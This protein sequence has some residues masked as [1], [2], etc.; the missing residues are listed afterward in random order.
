MFFAN[1]SCKKRVYI[2]DAE[3]GKQYFCPC[4]NRELIMK[5]GM[6]VASHFAH[7]IGECRDG[8]HY[9]PKGQW[10]RELQNYFDKKD[11][12]VIV[13]N[14]GEKHIADV[15]IKDT[16]IE[17]QHSQISSEEF[18]DRNNFYIDAGYKV[19]WVF[20]L[21]EKSWD[22]AIEHWKD[23]NSGEV[24]RWKRPFSG[25]TLLNPPQD[26]RG[27]I[28][29]CVCLPC[30]EYMDKKEWEECG[31]PYRIQKNSMEFVRQIWTTNV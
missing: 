25:L 1:D 30:N 23:V 28:S 6:F 2:S 13:S 3:K 11:Q 12:E 7:K 31:S 22:E 14:G 9:E 18:W 17:F 24:F 20:D 4:C 8:W 5:Q 10:H 21:I 26:W 29:I 19:V 27:S 16:V 15:L